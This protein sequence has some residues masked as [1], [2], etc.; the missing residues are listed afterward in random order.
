MSMR[1]LNEEYVRDVIRKLRDNGKLNYAEPYDTPIIMITRHEKE[2]V[3]ELKIG[4]L[5]HHVYIDGGTE[6][7]M[8]ELFD[9]I[10]DNGIKL[11][12]DKLVDIGMSVTQMWRTVL[13]QM[14]ELC[15]KI[16][17]RLKKEEELERKL[18]F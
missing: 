8:I 14:D 2:R 11:S 9:F 15:K 16:E 18:P 4:N 1:I 17:E 3:I 7:N 5:Q 6:A 10:N 12:D 13:D